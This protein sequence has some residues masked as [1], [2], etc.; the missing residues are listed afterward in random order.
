MNPENIMLSKELSHKRP[1]I[2]YLILHEMSRI[3][4]SVETES[5]LVTAG[6]VGAGK[7]M[8]DNQWQNYPFFDF[9]LFIFMSTLKL[10]LCLYY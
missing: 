3:G 5:R 7:R 8:S 1:H 10:F 6:G 9:L 2:I 4:Q